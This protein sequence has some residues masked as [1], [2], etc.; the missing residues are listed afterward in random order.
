M[1]SIVAADRGHVH[2]L[3]GHN[4]SYFRPMARSAA[5]VYGALMRSFL[6]EPRPAHPPGPLRRDWVLVA[7]VVAAGLLEVILRDQPVWPLLPAAVR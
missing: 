2:R 3:R 1:R 5:A 4:R 7:A 6:A